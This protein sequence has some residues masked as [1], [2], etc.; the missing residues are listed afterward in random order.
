MA[1]SDKQGKRVEV[2][3]SCFDYLFAAMIDTLRAGGDQG[4][5]NEELL[6]ETVRAIG[7]D[8][9]Y[10]L[11]ESSAQARALNTDAAALEVNV[12]KFICK[13]FWIEI[14]KKQVCCASLPPCISFPTRLTHPSIHHH[15]R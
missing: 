1:A 12:M 11:A 2:A 5:R 8:V 15:A 9:G 10:R 7:F 14:F 4:T 3:E 13:E 6:A